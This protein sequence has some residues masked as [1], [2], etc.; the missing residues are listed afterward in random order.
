MVKHEEELNTNDVTKN[1]DKCNHFKS[2]IIVTDNNM[3]NTLKEK[4]EKEL[5]KDSVN[6]NADD[7]G[8]TDGEVEGIIKKLG[9]VTIDKKEGIEDCT[10]ALNGLNI[11][12]TIEEN[13]EE[14]KGKEWKEEVTTEDNKA[15]DSEDTGDKKIS[16]SEIVVEETK[17]TPKDVRKEESEIKG[18]QEVSDDKVS[19][20][21]SSF[22]AKR[23]E[24][25]RNYTHKG[26][27][28]GIPTQ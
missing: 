25:I 20:L 6:G 3:D 26:P 2:E 7:Q 8:V 15:K 9:D 23:S 5:R 10:K 1:S 24:N 17:E 19:D 21:K 11:N 16:I 4:V 18:N 13:I 27:D 12:I 14:A 22:E 28:D